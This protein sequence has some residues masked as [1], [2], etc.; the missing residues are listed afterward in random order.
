MK[1]NVERTSLHIYYSLSDMKTN[2]FF[3]PPQELL[4]SLP[5]V[6]VYIDMYQFVFTQFLKQLEIALC[7]FIIENS[8][9]MFDILCSKVHHLR[10]RGV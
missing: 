1:V 4:K 8:Q 6:L 10:F 9:I 3:F 5:S 7:H 2:V